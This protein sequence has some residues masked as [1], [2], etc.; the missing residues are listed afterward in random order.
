MKIKKFGAVS[1][2]LMIAVSAVPSLLSTAPASAKYGTGKNVVEYLDR[3]IS[4]VNTGNG[5]MVSWR[6]LANDPDDA[7]FN[8]YRD[9]ELIYT[10]EGNSATSF[11]DAGGNAS[12]AYRVDT[13]SGGT[14]ISRDDC[15]MISGESYFDIP[16]DVPTGGDDYTYSPNDCSVGDADGDGQYEIFVKWDPSNSKDNSQ[17]GYTGNVYI[18]CYRL[19]GKKLWRVDLGKNIRAGAH[20]TQ[21]LVADFDLDG[22]AEMTCKT[23]DGTV[24]G[25]GKVIGDASKDYRNSSGYILSGPEYYTLFDGMTGAALDTVDYEYPRGEVSKKTWGDDYGNRCDRF[26]G[27]VCCL[28]GIHPS[29]VSVRGYYTRMTAVAYDVVDKKLVKRWG[30]DT[31]FAASSYTGYGNGNHN[32]MP[33]DV[34]GDG[35]EELFIGAVCLDDDGSV[36]WS[37]NLGHGDAMHLSDFLPDRPGLEAWVCHEHEPYGLSLL[38]AKDGSIIFH[39]DDPSNKDTG[40]CAAGNIYAGNPGAE[41]WG[42]RQGSVFDGSGNAVDGVPVPAMNFLIYW[43]GD[44]ERELLDNTTISE[45]TADKKINTLL[46]ASDCGSNNGTK[47]TPNLSADIF[48]DWREE[49]ILRTNDNKSLRIFC[50]PY[51]TD[52]RIT[53][54]MHDV[55]YRGQAASQQTSYNQPPHTSF[56]L[57]TGYELPER[58]NVTVMANGNSIA[59]GKLITS[60]KVNDKDNIYE[61]SVQQELGVGSDVF[62]DRAFKFADVPDKLKGAEYV[63]SACDSKR[64]AGTEATYY[65]GA[66]I[67]AYIALDSRVEEI[68][69]W[70]ADWTKTDMTLA[71]DGDPVVTYVVYQKDVLAGEQVTLGELSNG[72]VVNYVAMAVEKKAVEF[73][74]GDID[75]TKVVDAFDMIEMRKALFNAPTDE[76]AF[77]AADMDGSGNITVADAVIL[78]NQ[79]LGR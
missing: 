64:Y 47:A 60:L 69:S 35:K 36:L 40:R 45:I 27:A 71:D 16:L 79:L 10:S 23:A 25:T 76:R 55:Q 59:D 67:T 41:F 33:A 66:D 6:F 73:I 9:G 24:D 30:Y 7:V 17:S 56:F 19:D 22:K 52:Y 21:F 2:A 20:Y 8:L 15:S 26:L 62:G 57:G 49:L 65:A 70:L 29:A 32:C 18:D 38:D 39:Y 37:T 53:T 61:W 31:G 28:D 1:A 74:P 48:G 54:L 68:P 43:D 78:Q 46:S 44:L 58:P 13:L 51:T 63:R 12:S 5:M 4:A 3:G 72:S 42:A 34:D 14:V 75:D 77:L 50:T 11:L